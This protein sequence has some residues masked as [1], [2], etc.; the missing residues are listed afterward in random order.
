MDYCVPPHA[1]MT[2]GN[3]VVKNKS[4]LISV[5]CLWEPMCCS[6]LCA[7]A[8]SIP[9]S[10]RASVTSLLYTVC[11]RLLKRPCRPRDEESA[12]SWAAQGC[13]DSGFQIKLLHDL[14]T[15]FHLI[16]YL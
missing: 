3:L 15:T 9:D 16:L 4:T 12:K 6:C 7:I 1:H 8:L 11:H 14:A 10:T 13:H 2:L 5:S